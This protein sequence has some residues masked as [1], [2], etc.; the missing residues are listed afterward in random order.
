MT[1]DAKDRITFFALR[2]CPCDKLPPPRGMDRMMSAK[3]CCIE[4]VASLP[5]K[6]R[7]RRY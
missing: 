5:T 1:I 3:R 6:S 2:C 4:C 7:L